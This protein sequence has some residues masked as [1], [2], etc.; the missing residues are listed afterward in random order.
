M[1]SYIAAGKTYIKEV[2]RCVREILK[3]ERGKE[4][5]FHNAFVAYR[6][7]G[8][9]GQLN[10]TD[11]TD[12][13]SVLAAAVDR[14]SA[15]GGGDAPE[16]VC[17]AFHKALNLTWR[18]RSVKFVILICDAPCHNTTTKKFHTYG[19]SHVHA[20]D[21]RG[22]ADPDVQLVAFRDKGV[23]V[24]VT[25]MSSGVLEM[26]LTAFEVSDFNILCM[27]FPFLFSNCVLTTCSA[28]TTHPTASSN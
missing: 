14:E 10:V 9:A 26:M 3:K 20:S 22:Y 7:F 16:D 23:R 4:P 13:E 17:G 18:P 1:G 12:N 28:P 24:M 15:G 27:V 5:S 2:M 8:D 19:D 6:D 21:P 11:F 25:E